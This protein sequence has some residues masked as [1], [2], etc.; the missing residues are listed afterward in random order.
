MISRHNNAL[1]QRHPE[2]GLWL[3]DHH[4][5]KKWLDREGPPLW[6]NGIPGSGK[7]ILSSLIIEDLTKRYAGIPGSTLCFYYFSFSNQLERNVQ[8]F[9]RSILSQLASQ[10]HIAYHIIR[11]AYEKAQQRNHNPAT[12]GSRGFIETEELL[13]ILEKCTESLTE[14]CLVVDA[15]DECQDRPLLVSSIEQI[16]E[17][18]PIRT[19]LLCVSRNERDIERCLEQ[20]SALQICL[21]SQLLYEDIH[22]HVKDR[23]RNDAKLRRWPEAVKVEV[24][25]ALT[26]DA[27]GM[28]GIGSASVD[29]PQTYF[30]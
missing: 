16:L 7:T 23:L 2:T 30:V 21:D 18:K 25:E 19:N 8:S 24:E 5:Y 6:I 20:A 29:C 15:L 11:E 26:R 12:A 4:I 3:R 28:Y 22:V 1:H 17:W 10:S 9:L 14:V 13:S 27:N